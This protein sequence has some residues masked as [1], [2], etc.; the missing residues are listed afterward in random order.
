MESPIRK[1]QK[2]K[3]YQRH[4]VLRKIKRRQQRKA[5]Q[6]QKIAEKQLKRG[7]PKM[8]EGTEPEDD[9]FRY[10]QLP[11]GITV[12]FKNSS[13]QNGTYANYDN[14]KQ[15]F[16]LDG[17]IDAQQAKRKSAFRS[18][19]VP[20]YANALTGGFLLNLSPSQWARRGY[21]AVTGNL[22]PESWFGGNNGIVSD[23]YMQEHP[24]IGTGANFLFDSAM[25]GLGNIKLP[26]QK[27][28]LPKNSKAYVATPE[29]QMYRDFTTG[30]FSFPKWSS[31]VVQH[32]KYPK[33]ARDRFWNTTVERYVQNRPEMQP[34]DL[35][36]DINT[37]MNG[38]WYEFSPEAYEKAGY[39]NSVQ[40]LYNDKKDFISLKKGVDQSVFDHEA[41]HMFNNHFKLNKKELSALE[42]AYDNTFL[43]LPK[44]VNKNSPIYNYDTDNMYEEM[45]SL[46]TD[47][48]NLLFKPNQTWKYSIP[49]QNQFLNGVTK[50]DAINAVYNANDYGREYINQ[51]LFDNN[52]IIPDKYPD[53]FIKAM[54]IVPVGT[55]VMLKTTQK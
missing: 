28:E 20:A 32:T 10:A 14:P 49:T 7:L 47:A 37:T 43:N 8:D 50:Q 48:R 19:D 55:G 42:N 30:E 54:Q 2:Q 52:G 12:R 18:E 44:T 41:R 34:Q 3:E 39:P 16:Q 24:Y 36:R 33:I 51:L 4:K 9:E 23:K 40:G 22:T 17:T 46:N 1:Y 21:D 38:K 15:R 29:Q 31:N 11:N 6:M 35:Y 53:A 25:F 13:L 5:E 26:N 45:F 27:I